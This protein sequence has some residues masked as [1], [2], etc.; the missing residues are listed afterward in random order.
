M[1]FLVPLVVVA[2]ETGAS[3]WAIASAI[4][5]AVIGAVQYV[6][7]EKQKNSAQQRQ[8]DALR[9]TLG[10]GPRYFLGGKVA[11]GGH[12]LH[13]Q[14]YGGSDNPFETY[15]IKLADHRCKSLQTYIVDDKEYTYSASAGGGQPPFNISGDDMWK[16]WFVD[17]TQT[18]VPAAYL[19]NTGGTLWTANDIIKG[20]A[21]VYC[22]RQANDKVWKTGKPQLKFVCEG[23]YLYD[24]RKDST[25]P[26]GSGP[27]RWNDPSTW[28]YDTSLGLM[29]YNYGRGIWNN[30]QLMV[31]PG[32]SA[33]ELPPED[34][35]PCLN[36]CDETFALKAGGT[37]PKYHGS[38]VIKSDEPFDSILLDFARAMGGRIVPRRGSITIQP[39]ATQSVVRTFTDLDLCPGTPIRFRAFLDEPDRVNTVM[40]SYPDPGQLWELQSA[41]TRSDIA[42][43]TADNGRYYDSDNDY[44][45]LNV[46][47][48]VQRAMEFERRAARL[49]RSAEVI[50]PPRFMDIEAGDVVAWQSDRYLGG[51]TV[52]FWV[53]EEGEDESFRR[54][55]KLREYSDAIFSWTAASDELTPGTADHVASTPPGAL[56]IGGWGVSAFS[57]ASATATVPAIKV[58]WT[59]PNAKLGLR[60][61]LQVR[62][63]GT[64]DVGHVV[65][66]DPADGK[67]I[68]TENIPAEGAMEVRGRYDGTTDTT[69]DGTW[70][71]WTAVTVGAAVISPAAVDDSPYL[72]RD[73]YLQSWPPGAALPT[74]LVAVGGPVVTRNTVDKRY[75][76][77]AFEVTYPGAGAEYHYISGGT[78]LRLPAPSS[79]LPLLALDWEVLLKAGNFYRAGVIARMCYN[80]G[81]ADFEEYRFSLYDSLRDEMIAASPDPGAY[82]GAILS[83][84]VATGGAPGGRPT[85][86]QLY[87]MGNYGGLAGPAFSAKTLAWWK[88]GVRLPTETEIA[89]YQAMTREGKVTRLDQS[90]SIVPPSGAALPVAGGFTSGPCVTG[91]PVS[92]PVQFPSTPN[93]IVLGAGTFAAAL[94]GSQFQN[95]QIVAS[96]SGF[97]PNLRMTEA[98][99][100]TTPVTISNASGA[101]QRLFNKPS[102]ADAYDGIYTLT[103]PIRVYGSKPKPL[104]DYAGSCDVNIYSNNGSGWVLRAVRHPAMWNDHFGPDYNDITMT[105][106]ITP[107]AIGAGAANDFRI[108]IV[109]ATNGSTAFTGTATVDYATATAP[110]SA[111]RA[112]AGQPAFYVA[113]Q[114]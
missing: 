60:L 25:V 11:T 77:F 53:E 3:A 72:N 105:V 5:T 81:V 37:L 104:G 101:T 111:S 67:A 54:I 27:Q 66:A 114:S 110:A 20:C 38:C 47:Q 79:P 56:T 83:K 24:P 6:A 68:L 28:G 80:G 32:L 63:Q 78:Q 45:F 90:A 91:V 41:P 4:A 23:A 112:P 48:R 99:G 19:A 18:T 31:G 7:A 9:L 51:D 73:P 94:T 95:D 88:F 14:N 39:G 87:P 50:L 107:G 108:E 29:A 34:W 86:L 97:T 98:V 62:R 21:A 113:F 74:G 49:E 89:S 30:G 93:I 36:I 103:I 96:P 33:D 1:A 92:F 2:F 106:A 52:K 16:L 40:G 8:G 109:N 58:V 22:D 12:L 84:I 75:G 64:T 13:A 65:V 35:I 100:T 42:D 57:Q 10:E 26:G 17:G 102:S 85:S 15:P 82:G 59:P 55:W 71:A 44:P 43:I 46:H 70:T 76:A 69:R 61:L